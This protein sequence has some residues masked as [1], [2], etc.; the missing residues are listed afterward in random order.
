MVTE[1]MMTGYPGVAKVRTWMRGDSGLMTR[2]VAITQVRVG[3][4]ILIG[5]YDASENLHPGKAY[6]HIKRF[7]AFEVTDIFATGNP[8]GIRGNFRYYTYTGVMSDDPVLDG[9]RTYRLI[10]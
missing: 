3:E 6:Y 10:Q 4:V 5:I 7:A 9:P 2:P 1:W 8:K